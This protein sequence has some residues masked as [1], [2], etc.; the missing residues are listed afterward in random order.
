MMKVAIIDDSPEDLA[1]AVDYF[2]NY[3][4]KNHIEL[5]YNL[6]V[7]SYSDALEFIKNNLS[8]KFDL[9]I[10]DICMKEINGIRLAHFIRKNDAECEII[11]LTNSSEFLMDGYKVFAAGYF[12]KP[13]ADHA[14]EFDRTFKF[15]YPK[16][17]KK[18]QEIKVPLIKNDS[19]TI[20]YSSIY[21][22]EIE[23]KH[24][25][26]FVTKTGNYITSMSFEDCQKWL[27]TDARFLECYY[28]IIVNMDYII[29]LK[30]D[31][32]LLENGEKIPISFR[33]KKEAKRQYMQY[34][35][36]KV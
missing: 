12:I 28:R 26:C 30:E 33:R 18:H 2:T 25:L 15:I 16:L 17:L 23:D 32:F 9:V 20:P 8:E 31:D 34:L 13:L 11:F 36:H 5:S 35:A 19:I 24:R 21:Y 14:K 4:S 10:S 3:I 27:M 29:S 6:K 22:C 7:K 1:R